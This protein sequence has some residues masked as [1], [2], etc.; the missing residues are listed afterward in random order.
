MNHSLDSIPILM[1]EKKEKDEF[2]M[3]TFSLPY[4]NHFLS[5]LQASGCPYVDL[6][7]MD[8]ATTRFATP[9]HWEMECMSVFVSNSFQSTW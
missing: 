3:S 1:K 7:E 9:E 8:C 2:T 4:N 5:P 6:R